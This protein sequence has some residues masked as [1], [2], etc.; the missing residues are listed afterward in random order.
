[1]LIYQGTALETQAQLPE[2][3]QKQ[4][5]AD[6]GAIS[7][8]PGVTGGPFVEMKEARRR[9]LRPR[10]GRPRPRGPLRWC[11]RDPTLGDLLVATL[12]QVFREEGGAS[13][14]P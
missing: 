9:V 1:M 2:A 11:R 6:Y 10:G 3:E 7:Q 14:P 13:W 8:T 12:D 5:G 4:V